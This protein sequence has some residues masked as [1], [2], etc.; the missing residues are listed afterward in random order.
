MNP[1]YS[2]TGEIQV[3]CEKDGCF[4]RQHVTVSLSL[5]ATKK[6]IRE[7][8]LQKLGEFGWETQSDED[9]NITGNCSKHAHGT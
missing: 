8:I 9:G 4:Q 6:D 7:A 1:S 5:E 2:T 3:F